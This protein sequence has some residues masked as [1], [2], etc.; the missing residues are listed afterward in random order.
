LQATEDVGVVESRHVSVSARLRV[1]GEDREVE[2]NAPSD[3]V[4]GKDGNSY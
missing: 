3:V 2:R 1:T 4:H